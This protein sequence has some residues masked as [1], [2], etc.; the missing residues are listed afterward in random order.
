[1][2][3]QNY[4]NAKVRVPARWFIEESLA[5]FRDDVPDI[6]RAFSAKE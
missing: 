4:G 1:M 6:V 3:V 2:R 5:E